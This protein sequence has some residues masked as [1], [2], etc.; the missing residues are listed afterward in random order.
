MV[1]RSLLKLHQLQTDSE[2][3][4]S[5]TKYVN[6]VGFNKPDGMVLSRFVENLRRYGSFKSNKQV[7]YVRKKLLKYVK[8]IT[9]IA[10]G[11]LKEVHEPKQFIRSRLRRMQRP[12]HYG[13][14][15]R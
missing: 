6:G 1:E 14:R 3:A 4:Q 10:N 9:Q 8:Q 13:T 11:E 15:F 7:A 2:Q 5:E 12:P